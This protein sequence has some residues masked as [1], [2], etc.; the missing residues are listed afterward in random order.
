M[1]TPLT[2]TPLGTLPASLVGLD[3]TLTNGY[4]WGLLAGARERFGMCGISH[5]QLPLPAEDL[6]QPTQLCGFTWYDHSIA[7]HEAGSMPTLTP[8][9]VAVTLSR[10][11]KFETQE[12]VLCD[13]P[14]F[15]NL[16]SQFVTFCLAIPHRNKGTS[17]SRDAFRQCY[18]YPAP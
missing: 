2:A 3:A 6:F 10:Y 13:R 7:L 12:V 17:R 18:I 8:R 14:V 5:G 16:N 9:A 11:E 1:R 15:V 4:G